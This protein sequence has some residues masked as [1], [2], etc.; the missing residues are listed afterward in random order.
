MT[1]VRR[2]TVTYPYSAG[3][4]TLYIANILCVADCLV[5]VFLYGCQSMYLGLP[6]KS[7][8]IEL[9]RSTHSLLVEPWFVTSF[10]I[11]K[12]SSVEMHCRLLF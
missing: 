2:R 9:Y 6:S 4:N 7:Y 1:D 8:V 10:T 11:I 3:K 5:V 12:G